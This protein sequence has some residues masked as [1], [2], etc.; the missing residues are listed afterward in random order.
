[1]PQ[2]EF[3]EFIRSQAAQYRGFRL[4]MQSEVVGLLENNGQ[5]IGVRVRGPDYSTAV[6]AN[7]TIAADGRDRKLA[8]GL[9]WTFTKSAPP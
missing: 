2:W 8:N 4:R 6:H 5:V 7:V 3:L 1:M 9:I